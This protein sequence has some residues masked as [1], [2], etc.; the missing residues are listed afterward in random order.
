LDKVDSMFR[1]S[2]VVLVAA[3]VVVLFLLA[4]SI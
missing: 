4:A 3:L 2:I 1:G